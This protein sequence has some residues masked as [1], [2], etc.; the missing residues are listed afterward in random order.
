MYFLRVAVKA[1]INVLALFSFIYKT[2]KV[3]LGKLREYKMITR[4]S[5]VDSIY[6]EVLLVPSIKAIGQTARCV[7]ESSYS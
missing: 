2:E 7:F 4:Q 5:Q 6:L 1:E 3:L